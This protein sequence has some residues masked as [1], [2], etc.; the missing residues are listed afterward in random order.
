MLSAVSPPLS[1]KRSRPPRWVA[2][3][4]LATAGLGVAALAGLAWAL[5]QADARMQRDV[6]VKSRAVAYT[7]DAVTIERG[8]RLYLD[9]GC[10]HCHGADGRGQEFASGAGLRLVAPNLTPAGAVARYQ[11]EDWNSAI[12]HG[13]K[14]NGRPV[15]AMPSERYHG[16]SM[17]ELSA[18]VS[19]LRQ[20]PPAPGEAAVVQWPLVQRVRYGLGWDTDAAARIDHRRP[21]ARSASASAMASMTTPDGLALPCSDCGPVW[22]ITWSAAQHDT[23]NATGLGQPM[24]MH[25]SQR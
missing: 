2:S 21:P 14:P 24:R 8:R 23:A 7:T 11:P 12:R 16:W 4:A 3:L 20:L 19:Y 5:Q 15:L 25:A 10:V 22:P 17:D 9:A 1:P 13:V 6:A 18:L